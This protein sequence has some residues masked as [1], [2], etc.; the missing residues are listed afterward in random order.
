MSYVRTFTDDQGT[1]WEA[2]GT[3]TTVAHGRLG[4]RL[5]FRRADRAEVVPGDVTF[6][7]EEAADF[8]LATMSDRELRRRL[9]L[10]LEARRGAASPRGQ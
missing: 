2:I 5:A 4:A 9:R 3:P 7:S 10:A 1:L 6:N 8:A